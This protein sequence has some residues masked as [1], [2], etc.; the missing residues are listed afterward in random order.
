MAREC[1][2]GR[3]LAREGK[4]VRITASLPAGGLPSAPAAPRAVHPHPPVAHLLS[5]GACSP[6]SVPCVGSAGHRLPGSPAGRGGRGRRRRLMNFGVTRGLARIWE[7]RA[8]I[9]AH[10]AAL[11]KAQPFRPAADLWRNP[12]RDGLGWGRQPG[13]GGAGLPAAAFGLLGVSGALGSSRRSPCAALGAPCLLGPPRD[14]ETRVPSEPLSHPRWLAERVRI[15]DRNGA[16]PSPPLP[17]PQALPP[18][19]SGRPQSSEFRRFVYR[20]HRKLKRVSDLF[21]RL[22]SVQSPS[23]SWRRRGGPKSGVAGCAE[24]RATPDPPTHPPLPRAP[25]AAARGG[26]AALFFPDLVCRGEMW[27]YQSTNIYS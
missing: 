14:L 11:S 23:S 22:R 9:C 21:S 5:E 12:I 7:P 25:P 4:K 8:L 18:T 19:P 27:L 2:V 20:G 10:G 1:P 15:F 17:T 6:S 16:K 24:A 3:A 13:E 26:R